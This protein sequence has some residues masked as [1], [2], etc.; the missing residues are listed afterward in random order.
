MTRYYFLAESQAPRE[1]RPDQIIHLKGNGE[2]FG[3]VEEAYRY[4]KHLIAERKV[5]NKWL[6]VCF[7]ECEPGDAIVASKSKVELIIQNGKS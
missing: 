4:G 6:N 7:Q 2:G 3:S 1:L 5:Q